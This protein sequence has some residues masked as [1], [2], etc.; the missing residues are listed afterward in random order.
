MRI[1]STTG[2]KVKSS[3]D[4]HHLIQKFHPKVVDI[5]LY[6][7]LFE[8]QIK[9]AKVTEEMWASHLIGL[10]PNDMAQLIAREPEEV[11]E[12]Y[13]QIKQILLKRYELSAEMFSQ[14]FIKHSK[15]ADG[16]WKG[17]MYQ[18]RTYLQEWIKGL[19][20]ERFEQLCDLISTDQIKCRV[21][22]EV[23]EYFIDE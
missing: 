8:R 5:S 1:E 6:L 15:N 16:T 11:T 14:M 2:E 9:R 19:E 7:T 13:E 17:F 3:P 21:P 10:L 18:I 4:V 12:D 23:K 22:T 20:V